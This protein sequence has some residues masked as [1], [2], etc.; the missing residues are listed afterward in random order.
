[1][2]IRF[3]ILVLAATR[4]DCFATEGLS[5]EEILDHVEQ[6]DITS[7]SA[8]IS[9][10]KIDPILDRRELRT[11][12]ILFQL[13]ADKKRKAAILFDT[14]IIG[15]RKEQEQKHYIFS[16]R[17]MAEIDRENK[18]FIKRELVP[19]N[20]ES[21]DPFELGNG[22]IPLP[23]AQKKE[24]VLS[25]FDVEKIEKPID[26]L[27]SKLDAAVLGL[28]L[29]PKKGDDLESIDLYYDPINWIPIGVQTIEQDGTKRLSKLTDVKLNVLCD[30]EIAL[31]NMETPDPKEW[32]IDV[33][34]Y[35]N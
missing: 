5:I 25:K 31:I 35:S 34:P 32:S 3:F 21:V 1:M 10:M 24:I 14:R 8:N 28:R 6:A 9:Y 12:K 18:Q 20:S 23:I 27:L 22:P 4:G 17:F 15:R 11:G 19:P 33:R 26:G 30:Q 13:D 16:G 2:L 7:I 29:V